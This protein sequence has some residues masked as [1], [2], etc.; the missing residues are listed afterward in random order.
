MQTSE[1]FELLVMQ[2]ETSNSILDTVTCLNPTSGKIPPKMALAFPLVAS[3]ETWVPQVLEGQPQNIFSRIS[4]GS[5]QVGLVEGTTDSVRISDV[6]YILLHRYHDFTETLAEKYSNQL[7][8]A[9]G[10]AVAMENETL[11]EDMLFLAKNRSY[12]AGSMDTVKMLLDVLRSFQ[13]SEKHKAYLKTL[14]LRL[15]TNNVVDVVYI[16][17]ELL[18]T[19]LGQFSGTLDLVD[20]KEGDMSAVLIGLF[21]SI[22][23]D[24]EFYVKTTS[25]KS[26]AELRKMFNLA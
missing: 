26:I 10:Q 4:A 11:A 12:F 13:G 8:V 23:S 21:L 3:F 6:K 22:F 15:T 20:E 17:Q 16:P 1:G 18:E 24:N 9:Y 25:V 7:A 14:D 2:P 19:S 5:N